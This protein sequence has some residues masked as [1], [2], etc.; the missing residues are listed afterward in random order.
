MSARTLIATI[1]LDPAQ[2]AATLGEVLELVRSTYADEGYDSVSLELA[3]EGVYRVIAGTEPALCD[4]CNGVLE[5]GELLFGTCGHCGG[6]SL[7][8]NR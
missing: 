5:G 4:V 1:E 2:P 7:N 6:R 3:S 8:P